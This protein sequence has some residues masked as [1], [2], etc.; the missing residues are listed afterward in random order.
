MSLEAKIYVLTK[1]EGGRHK[2]FASNYK[3][4]FFFRTANVTGTILL[5][6]NIS[7]VMQVILYLLL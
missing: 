7:A 2:S 3:P 4:H 6:E 5:P 1:K